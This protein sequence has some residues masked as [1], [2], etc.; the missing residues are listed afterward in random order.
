MGKPFFVMERRTGAVVRGRWP[1][2]LP[3]GIEAKRAVGEAFVDALAAL[4]QVDF[5]AIGLADLGRPDGFAERQVE[6]WARRWERARHDEVPDMERLAQGLMRSIP[7]P[8]R[9]SLLHGDFKLDNTMVSADGDLVAVFDWDM[10]TLGDPLVDVGTTLSYF[11]GPPEV[12]IIVPPDRKVLDEAISVDDVM[13]RYAAATGLD[14]SQ[15][16]WYRALGAFRV[17]V[18]IQQIHIRFVRG[19]T[20]DNRFAVLGSVVPPLAAAGL[21]HVG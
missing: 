18:I 16:S 6:G 4:H 20:A 10:A 1:D 5:A 13:A 9:A 15:I 19:Q 8:Q 7:N 14:L 2:E 21:A 12:E 11:D 17:A 3:A